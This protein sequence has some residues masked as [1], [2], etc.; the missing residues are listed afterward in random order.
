ME[1]YR[2]HSRTAQ[3]R[4]SHQFVRPT[5]CDVVGNWND[6]QYSAYLRQRS[7]CCKIVTILPASLM[8]FFSDYKSVQNAA[9]RL[10]SGARRHDHITPVLVSLHWL[11][12]R[13]RL[14]GG[15]YVEV[16]VYMMQPIAIWLT[17]V[18]RP[19]PCMVA[20]NSAFHRRLGLL[21]PRTRTATSQRSFA[22][23]GPRIW[24]SLPADLRTPDTALCSFKRYLKAHLFQQQPTLLL[25]GGLSTV[26]PQ[27]WR[28][29]E[30]G[31][32]LIFRLTY[33]LT[34]LLIK[35]TQGKTQATQCGEVR[36]DPVFA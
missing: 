14:D 5:C 26:R 8:I 19:I 18:C 27:L 36:L 1:L 28:F 15:A 22:V 31:A 30:F 2:K 35:Q 33:L 9:A 4:N 23:N 16:S 29:S 32:D 10:V 11:P 13:Q 17:C 3:K 34:Y 7:W 21:V 24:N 20:S 25:A 12:V 6:T